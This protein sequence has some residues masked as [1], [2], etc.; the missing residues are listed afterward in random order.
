MNKQMSRWKHKW[1]NSLQSSVH[2]VKFKHLNHHYLLH[3]IDLNILD[4]GNNNCIGTALGTEVFI[5][6]AET[7]TVERLMQT[8]DN[9]IVTSVKWINE[10]NILAVGLNNGTIEVIRKAFNSNIYH[11]SDCYFFYL[12]YMVYLKLAD[13]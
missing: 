11:Y 5:W 1:V 6:H 4:W 8:E 2:S 12:V 9:D 3:F 7:G 13:N 10:G